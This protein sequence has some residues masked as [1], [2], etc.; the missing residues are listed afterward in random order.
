M[1]KL[2]KQLVKIARKL[3]ALDD[4]HIPKIFRAEVK[5]DNEKQ[6]TLKIIFPDLKKNKI[7]SNALMHFRKMFLHT[8]TI[9]SKKIQIPTPLIDPKKTFDRDLKRKI[10]VEIYDFANKEDAQSIFKKW[11]ELIG[12]KVTKQDSGA[13]HTFKPEPEP[14]QPVTI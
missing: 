9:N 14:E 1:L 7:E 6:I 10:Q 3:L 11:Q 12:P 2:A 13:R 4:A 8:Y 5:I